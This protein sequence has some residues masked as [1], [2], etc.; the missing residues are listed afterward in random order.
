VP[1][2][3]APLGAAVSGDARRR[4]KNEKKIYA[5]A[6]ARVGQPGLGNN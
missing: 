6:A 2:N 5:A 4:K 3:E 1:S